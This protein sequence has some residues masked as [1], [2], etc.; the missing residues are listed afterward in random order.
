MCGASVA[1][2]P[3]LGVYGSE[4]YGTGQSVDVETALRSFTVWAAHQMFLEDK[5]GTIEPGKYADLAVWDRDA[6]TVPT[7][8]LRDMACDMTVF[9][10]EVVFEREG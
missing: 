4:P 6:L 8:E 9:N 7:D 10:G 3:L 5:V 1:R 2:R